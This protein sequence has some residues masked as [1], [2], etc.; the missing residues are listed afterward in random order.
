MKEIAIYVEGGGDTAQQKAE[1]R[2]GFDQLLGAVKQ[3]ARDKRIGW[4]LVPSGSR[5]STHQA[6]NNALENARPGTLCVLLVDSEGPLPAE[7]TKPTSENDEARNAWEHAVAVVRRDHLRNRDGWSLDQG[8]PEQIHLMVQCM[9]SWLVADPAGMRDY[10]KKDFHP[11][12]LPVRPNLEEE[13]KA[14]VYR[15]IAVATRETSKKEYSEANKS[16]IKHASKILAAISATVVERRC[17]R[18]AT[19]TSWLKRS[20]DET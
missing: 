8:R 19:F 4:K 14:E 17:P 5:N 10:Y 13:P 9:E 20:I 18:F 6:F 15:K 3:A 11:D 7:S 16:K 12:R 2:N 1:L